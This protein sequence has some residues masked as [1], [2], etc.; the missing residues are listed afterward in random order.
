MWMA[1]IAARST[2]KRSSAWLSMVA[3]GRKTRQPR[4]QAG[5]VDPRLLTLGGL[6]TRIPTRMTMRQESSID[7]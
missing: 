1:V 5:A 2:N 3:Q 4:L 7:R 6:Q